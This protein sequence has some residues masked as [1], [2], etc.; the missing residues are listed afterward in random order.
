MVAPRLK[1]ALEAPMTATEAGLK[2]LPMSEAFIG[3]F[4]H[5]EKD[6]IIYDQ[7]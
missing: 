7:V 1:S 5:N 4:M 3:T 2:N 6:Q